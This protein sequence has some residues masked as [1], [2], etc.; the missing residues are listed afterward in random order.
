MPS[1]KRTNSCTLQADDNTGVS[2]EGDTLIMS[3]PSIIDLS[4]FTILYRFLLDVDLDAINQ[5]LLDL[6]AVEIL[7]T[8]G[9]AAFLCL[10]SLAIKRHMRVLMFETP[11]A[12]RK[13]LTS[14]F[15]NAAWLDFREPGPGNTAEH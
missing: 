9:I 5:V 13:Q 1:D 12:I 15:P 8:S 2:R 14:V 3:I 7:C 11:D 4:L 6:S 10:E